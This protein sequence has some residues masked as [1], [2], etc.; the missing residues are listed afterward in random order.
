MR[1]AFGPAKSAK[2]EAERGLPF[3]LVADLD[4]GSATFREDGRYAYPEARFVASG[5]V[6]GRLHIVC[7]TPIEGGIRVISFRKANGREVRK[8]E[9]ETADR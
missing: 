3:G 2:N 4:W 9:Q 1:I 8:H 5:F 7:F 6:A